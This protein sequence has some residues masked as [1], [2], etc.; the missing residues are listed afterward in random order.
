M[1]N[2]KHKIYVMKD[3]NEGHHYERERLFNVP[4]RGLITA[5]S[6]QGKT[7]LIGNMFLR[8]EFY[9]N[10]F[11]PEDIYIF[12]ESAKNDDKLKK[13]IEVRDIPESNIHHYFDEQALE[14]LY[15]FLTEEYEKAIEEKKKP[16]HSVVILDDC[17]FDGS[18][19]YSKALNHVY[20]NGRHIQCSVIICSQKHSLISTHI[21]ENANF[22]II[23]PCSQK[24]L[25][26]VADDYNYLP[27][28]RDFIDI[29]RKYTPKKHNF[30]VVNFTNKEK[31]QI[32]QDDTF[33][34]I[35]E[36]EKYNI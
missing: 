8:D 12:S 2:K 14:I 27:R 32:Y 35:L 28:K 13:L 29:F 15:D 11:K 21:R 34:Y 3:E 30:F 17:A 24:Q 33:E 22:S 5:K 36:K 18:L 9:L 7:N 6:G 4:F 16:V 10:D 19:K 20:M 26:L 1:S 25:E 31:N 23:F